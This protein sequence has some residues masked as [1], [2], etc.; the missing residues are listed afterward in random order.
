MP[1]KAEQPSGGHWYPCPD[2]NR[3]TRFRKPVLY[4]PE[5]QGHVL[6][7]ADSRLHI[8]CSA[9]TYESV[10]RHTGRCQR[11]ENAVKRQMLRP[12]EATMRHGAG[13]RNPPP[14]DHVHVLTDVVSTQPRHPTRLGPSFRWHD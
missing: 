7:H 10:P 8:S 1:C 4:P 14:T 9:P 3:G 2:S 5:L 6:L 11:P 13:P 12:P